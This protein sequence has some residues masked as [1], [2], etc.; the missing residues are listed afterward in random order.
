MPD[1]DSAGSSEYMRAS[2]RVDRRPPA[3]VLV[4]PTASG[5][6]A[7]ALQWA[8]RFGGE[9]LSVDSALVY[10]GLDIGSA[11]PSAAEQA[12][13][14]H[15]LIDVCAPHQP[16][17][18]ADFC[19]DARRAIDEILARGRMPVL[20]GGTGLYLRALFDGLAP[21]PEA[22]PAIRSALAEEAARIGWA[23]LHGELAKV[24]PVAAARI[25]PSDPQRIGRALEVWRSSGIP[26]SRW[27]ASAT[28]HRG[29]PVRALK[30]ALWPARD[31]LAER[32]EWRFDQMIAAGLL[33]EV[34]RLRADERLHAGLPALRAVGYRQAWLHLDGVIDAEEF[35]RQTLAATRQLAKRQRT[36]LR[37]EH[38]LLLVDAETGTG[39]ARIDG[40]LRD[41]LPT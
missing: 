25:R 35:R 36:W 31:L 21:M 3:L 8:R 16:Y 30:F 28:S 15:H 4:G 7:L 24:D 17:S 2:A 10:R 41:F 14:P 33:A 23:G 38:D 32:I 34:E 37:G 9:I 22:D 11:K 1:T 6:S 20:V 18:A 13:I 29:L 40:L 39:R 12:E 19:R 5:K 27:Q 26:I